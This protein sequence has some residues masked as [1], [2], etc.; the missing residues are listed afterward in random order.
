MQLK[1]N[2][3]PSKN[4]ENEA[5]CIWPT[6]MFLRDRNGSYFKTGFTRVPFWPLLKFHNFSK[7]ALNRLLSGYLNY[8]LQRH[9]ENA[10][11]LNTSS[12][13]LRLTEGNART[14]H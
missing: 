10:T 9:G 13:G 14:C 7:L 11:L 1:A 5:D 2:A 8:Y 3:G 6:S 4:M 12:E